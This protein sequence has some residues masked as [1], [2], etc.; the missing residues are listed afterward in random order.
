MKLVILEIYLNILLTF[1]RLRLIGFVFWC[2]ASG[3][4]RTIAPDILNI[5]WQDR[6][7]YW[8]YCKFIC[9]MMFFLLRH[10]LVVEDYK[11]SKRRS[12]LLSLSLTLECL[13]VLSWSIFFFYFSC[14]PDDVLCKIS[15]W[16]NKTALNSS[17]HKP[18]DLLQQV[19]IA[20]EL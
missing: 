7:C 11:F 18:S 16:A 5:F 8:S 1:W 10:F 6:V 20:H 13:G 19:E 15:F 14:L 3:V 12:Y 4:T 9:G 17:C 2:K